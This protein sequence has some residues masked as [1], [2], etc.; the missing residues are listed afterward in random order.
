MRRRDIRKSNQRFLY[1]MT[2]MCLVVLTVVLAFWWM[3]GGK[4]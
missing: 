2:A 3:A 1:A 4:F